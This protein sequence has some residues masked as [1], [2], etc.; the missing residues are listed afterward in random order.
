MQT[1]QALVSLDELANKE[2]VS[3]VSLSRTEEQEELEEA[4]HFSK[5][6][7]ATQLIANEPTHLHTCVN[8]SIY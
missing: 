8:L 5:D 4:E 3:V 2:K 6:T 7:Y 1:T